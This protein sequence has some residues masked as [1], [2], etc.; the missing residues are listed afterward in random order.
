MGERGAAEREA[1]QH[2][3]P[4][5]GRERADGASRRGSERG[6]QTGCHLQWLMESESR[7]DAND[8]RLKA[9]N[10]AYPVGSVKSE[11]YEI[12]RVFPL[13]S[14]KIAA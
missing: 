9:T 1:R 5:Q 11:I 8:S 10:G 3:K 7:T 12:W 14:A 4:R 2:D 6:M 13:N